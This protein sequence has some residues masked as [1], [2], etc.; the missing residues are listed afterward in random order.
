M[1]VLPNDL[2]TRITADM[3]HAARLDLAEKA[4]FLA[5]YTGRLELWR[6]PGVTV[7]RVRRF[8]DTAL[9]R[10]CGGRCADADEMCDEC[11]NG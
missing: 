2:A 6:Y 7:E 1:P 3:R 9:E 10:A 8:A 5:N 11:W 4:G